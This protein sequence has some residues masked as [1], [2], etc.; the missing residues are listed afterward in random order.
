MKYGIALAALLPFMA[1]AQEAMPYMHTK[2]AT[3][4][5]ATVKEITR[6]VVFYPNSL[7]EIETKGSLVYLYIDA[8][9]KANITAVVK[10]KQ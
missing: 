7:Y 2:A 9:G 1:H 6:N 4:E 8:T 3:V 10:L 5:A